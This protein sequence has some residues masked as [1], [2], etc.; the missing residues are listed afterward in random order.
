MSLS[1]L[2]PQMVA[3]DQDGEKKRVK[4]SKQVKGVGSPST[5]CLGRG[6]HYLKRPPLLFPIPLF[7][8]KALLGLE[9]DA[10]RIGSIYYIYTY[11]TRGDHPFRDDSP[12]GGKS[13]YTSHSVRWGYQGKE[14]ECGGWTSGIECPNPTLPLNL[15]VPQGEQKRQATAPA[16]A[17]KDRNVKVKPK[18]RSSGVIQDQVKMRQ[19][20]LEKSLVKL[21]PGHQVA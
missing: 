9:P 13:I 11:S 15:H 18:K 2:D 4:I 1:G 10:V 21:G 7:R 5:G 3:Q 17:L 12:R 6:F 19:V 14:G 8:A 16:R 20:S